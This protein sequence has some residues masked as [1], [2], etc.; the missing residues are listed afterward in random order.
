MATIFME[1]T[2]LG[3]ITGWMTVIGDGSA[4]ASPVA[5]SWSSYSLQV[6]GSADPQAVFSTAVSTFYGQGWIRHNAFG[7]N[8][9]FAFL[10]PNGNPQ[11]S[12]CTNAS[13]KITLARG[14]NQF[15]LATGT[16]TLA[17]NTWYYV[18]FKVVISATVGEMVVFINGIEETF[19]WVTGTYNTQNTKNDA[20]YGTVDTLRFVRSSGTS[21]FDDVIIND[22]SDTDNVSYPAN[23]G[24]TA[25][26]PNAAGDS[27]D[28]ARGGADSGSNY[29]Q[30]DER[31]GNDATDYVYDDVVDEYDLY[32]LPATSWTTVASVG[33]AIKA[34]ASD[35]GLGY[36]AHMVKYDTNAD[37]AADTENTGSDLALSTTWAHF[38]KYYNRQPDSTSWTAAKVNALQV[39]V[40]VR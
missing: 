15:L 26:M 34:A 11:C 39:G 25:L 7:S 9:F 14:E 13:G 21:W 24:I 31:P 36:I 38:I 20:T 40:K 30:V 5:G 10:A 27:T 16:S 17:I 8:A 23:L 1:A 4:V 2:E 32:N 28:L 12:I 6:N 37:A 22:T 35:G 29:G 19:S 3:Q 33:L 18:Q